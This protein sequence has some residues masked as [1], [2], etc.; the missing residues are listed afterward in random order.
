MWKRPPV[1]QPMSVRAP[2][3]SQQLTTVGITGTNGKTSTTRWIAACLG[4]VVR[5][6]AQV[7]T[8]G[9]FLDDMPFEAAPDFGGFLATMRAA[10]DRGGRFAAIELTSEALARGFAREWPCGIG[11]FTNLTHDHLDAHGSPEHYLASKAQLFLSLRPGGA[12]VLN[13]ADPASELITEVIPSGVRIVRYAV[14]SRGETLRSPDL[15][16]TAVQPSWGGTRITIDARGEL[17]H[18]PKALTL[19]AIGDVYAENALA[20]L[21]AALVAGVPPE[22]AARALA[23]APV[24]PGRFQV[25]A[26]DRG[27]RVVIDYAHTPDA[28]ARTLATARSLC[29]GKLW[30][31]FGAGGDRDKNKRQPMGAAASCADHVMLTSD[32]PRSE[33]P[34]RIAEQI[35]SGI[36]PHADVRIKLDR[37]AAIREAILDALDGDVV[38]IAGKGHEVG[39]VVGA[40]VLPFDD[41]VEARAALGGKDA[42][43]ARAEPSA[44]STDRG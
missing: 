1:F 6:V 12:A 9:S 28:L 43:L 4:E 8:L 40:R 19:Q 27:P 34:E 44:P 24:P 30:V 41:A 14:P 7:T 23:N 35:R 13:A 17:A 39:Q 36:G 18:A 26:H 25:L 38:V 37:R 11:V 42:V 2:K 5:P 33:A 22:D 10:I 3:W 29:D 20:A 21:A 16:A 15:W 32:N 31:V